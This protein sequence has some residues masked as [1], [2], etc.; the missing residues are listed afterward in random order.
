MSNFIILGNGAYLKFA[1]DGILNSG[2]VRYIDFESDQTRL[3]PVFERIT[4]SHKVP[5]SCKYFMWKYG[6]TI[7]TALKTKTIFIIY[8]R[9]RY[10]HSKVFLQYLRDVYPNS[11]FVYFFTNFITEEWLK[12]N[13]LNFDF[14]KNTDLYD[15][16]I[17]FNKSDAERY[18]FEYHEHAN[19]FHDI[20]GNEIKDTFDVFFCGRD[21]NRSGKI[22]EVYKKLTENGFKCDFRIVRDT[23]CFE[24]KVEGIQYYDRMIPYS[25]II[26]GINNSK[27]ILDIANDSKEKGQ[28]LRLSEAIAYKKLLL[29][30]NMNI[31]SNELYNSNQIVLFGEASRINTGEIKRKICE[32]N[33]SN[34]EKV[35]P[36]KLLTFIERK[37]DEKQ[38]D[39]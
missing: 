22:T 28:S 15:L 19:T 7:F 39:Q 29:T 24:S 38:V 9:N 36:Q 17:T 4:L 11:K 26:T 33:Y 23:K 14:V 35:S 32:G 20:M 3:N 5:D 8:E 18:G 25:E 1:L 12:I 31:V 10:A 21:K 2:G 37:I 6:Q 16:K 27:C 34:P 30:D 13:A